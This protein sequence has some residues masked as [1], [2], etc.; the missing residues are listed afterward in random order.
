MIL[1]PQLNKVSQIYKVPHTLESPNYIQI[2]TSAVFKMK[3]RCRSNL[4]RHNS[5]AQLPCS[6][7]QPA[8]PAICH[9]KSFPTYISVLY[10]PVEFPQ[11]FTHYK[12]ELGNLFPTATS[13]Q[14]TSCV[15]KILSRLN[16]IN[17]L[18]ITCNFFPRAE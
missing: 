15:G 18:H 5:G 17:H 10:P 16:Y 1:I 12:P 13:T 4:R 9:K 11:Y 3:Q 14:P 8:S 6:V 2:L 7:F